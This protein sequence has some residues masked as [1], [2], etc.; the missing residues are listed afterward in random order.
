MLEAVFENGAF[1]L[2]EPSAVTLVDGQHVRL[3]AETGEASDDV[4]ALA[5]QVHDGLS[6]EEMDDVGR[7]S[8]DRRLFFDDR[9]S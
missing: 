2:V 8:F 3:R 6:D 5:E 9:P 4:L 1:R 7:I